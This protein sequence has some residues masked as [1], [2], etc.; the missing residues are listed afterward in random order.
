MLQG[1]RELLDSVDDGHDSEFS[2]GASGS[3]LYADRSIEVCS[4][5][6][7]VLV[8]APAEIPF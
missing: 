8:Y 2:C 6:G 1:N 3:H 7:V 4:R 5:I